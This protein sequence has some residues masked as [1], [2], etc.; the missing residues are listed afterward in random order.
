MRR[1]S[2][3]RCSLTKARDSSGRPTAG[4]GRHLDLRRPATLSLFPL[5]PLRVVPK[6]P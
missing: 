6:P 4:I 5:T 1:S 3:R 2:P